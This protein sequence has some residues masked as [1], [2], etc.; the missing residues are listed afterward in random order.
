MHVSNKT[1]EIIKDAC[2]EKEYVKNNGDNESNTSIKSTFTILAISDYILRAAGKNKI[3]KLNPQNITAR[4]KKAAKWYG[5]P[6]LTPVSVWESGMISYGKKLK[7]QK[8]KELENEDYQRIHEAFGLNPNS[9]YQT[10]IKIE[11]LL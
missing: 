1:I 2:D 4:L 6:Y 3:G 11:K 8:E 5:N 9:W 7:E 10:R